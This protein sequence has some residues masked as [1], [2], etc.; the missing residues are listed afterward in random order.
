[1]LYF[2]TKTV[3]LT[4]KGVEEVTTPCAVKK[5]S[6]EKLLSI[7]MYADPSYPYISKRILIKESGFF[8][9]VTVEPGT[10]I[11]AG[12]M[13]PMWGVSAEEV[14]TIIKSAEGEDF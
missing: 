9:S 6:I 4:M 13:I 1:M 8:E 5:G 2:Y 14:V 7:T 12:D 10:Q 3:T 11:M